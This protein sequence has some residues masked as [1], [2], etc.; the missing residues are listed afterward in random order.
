MESMENF[1]N[2]A[3]FQS[4][5]GGPARHGVLN[6]EYIVDLTETYPTWPSLL[7]ASS[8]TAP[9]EELETG[10]KSPLETVRLLAPVD[11]SSRVFGVALNY[12]SHVEEVK[13]EVPEAPIIFMVPDTAVIGPDADVRGLESCTFLDYE[14][15]LAVVIGSTASRVHQEQAYAVVAGVTLFNDVTGRDLMF[16]NPAKRGIPDWLSA[17]GLD[18]S[19]PIG[20]HVY[21]PNPIADIEDCEFYME[22][23][24]QRVQ[25]GRAED[26]I[27]SIPYLISFLSHRVTL[28]PGDVIATGT[29]TG[30]GNG[31]GVPLVAGD[32]LVVSSPQIGTL[33]NRVAG[34]HEVAT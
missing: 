14:A 3:R 6:G 2:V 5:E 4:L 26:R 32:R 27:F 28:R 23:N 33:A 34:N 19:T 30:T 8:Q 9:R 7:Q 22:V 15:E 16:A 13:R 17:K 29:P 12:R 25:Q 1:R 24:G 21:R 11:E 18:R 10:P 31:R 20:P